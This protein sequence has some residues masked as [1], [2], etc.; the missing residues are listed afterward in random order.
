MLET[1]SWERMEGVIL[2]NLVDKLVQSG[3]SLT[4]FD[5]DAILDLVE[6]GNLN[7]SIV[8]LLKDFLTVFKENQFTLEELRS[9]GVNARTTV[10]IDLFELLYESYQEHLKSRQELD[11]ADLILL[12]T[13]AVVANPEMVSFERIIV[14]EY[15]DISRGRFNFL[16]AL[17]SATNDSRILSC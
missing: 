11:F 14:D 5:P 4:A 15:Q 17:Q 6:T 1:Y 12:A 7:K 16:K 13:E 8:A 3:V 2:P 9:N 10:F